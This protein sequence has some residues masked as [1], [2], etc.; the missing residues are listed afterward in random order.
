MVV[1]GD[2]IEGKKVVEYLCGCKHPKSSHAAREKIGSRTRV[3]N[4]YETSIIFEKNMG[5]CT[6]PGCKCKGYKK[7]AVLLD[8]GSALSNAQFFEC[9]E[10]G[11]YLYTKKRAKDHYKYW[12][13]ICKPCVPVYYK[14]LIDDIDVNILE[15]EQIE[16]YL[17]KNYPD[18]MEKNLSLGI[19]YD[20]GY[21]CG[22]SKIYE[23]ISI[24]RI[25]EGRLTDLREEKNKWE[26]FI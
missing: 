14:K 1:I 13:T 20:D 5:K 25:I 26:R 21:S 8:D 23:D 19:D 7:G 10:C 6:E 24:M 17:R 4:H 3:G 18:Q 11:E 16:G 15:L 12:L 9:D 22:R 2:K